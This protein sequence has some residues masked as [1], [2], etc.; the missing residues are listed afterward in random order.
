MAYTLHTLHT[1]HVRY[2]RYRCSDTESVDSHANGG[3]AFNPTGLS[4]MMEVQQELRRRNSKP[5]FKVWDD[6]KFY[7]EVIIDDSFYTQHL[8]HSIAA[9]FYLP[10]KV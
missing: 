2:I 4:H 5:R 6:H 10:T 8:P 1:L 9:V 7:N 3:C